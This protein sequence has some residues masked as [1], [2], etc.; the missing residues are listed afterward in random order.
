MW[1]TMTDFFERYLSR[2]VLAG[3]V[4]RVGLSVGLQDVVKVG[5]HGRRLHISVQDGWRSN[6][7]RVKPCVK[8]HGQGRSDGVRWKGWVPCVRAC[9]PTC[10]W[11]LCALWGTNPPGRCLQKGPGTCSRWR[12]R[13]CC[14]APRRPLCS[15]RENKRGRRKEFWTFLSD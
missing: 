12:R 8:R 2:H 11:C 1:S 13:P 10:C 4:G 7:A 9:V 14:E 5:A 15:C 6:A 3:P